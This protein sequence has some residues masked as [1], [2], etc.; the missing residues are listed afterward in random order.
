MPLAVVTRSG[1]TCSWS[2]ANQSPV[3]QKP[4]WISSAMKT[5]PLARQYAA[6]A[7]QE[8]VRRHDEA[9]LALHRLDHHGGDVLLADLRVDQA[10]HDVEGFLGALGRAA[11]PAERIGHRHPV[12]LAGE[13]PEALLVG[14]VLGGHG[15]RQVGP[16][17]VGVVEDHDRVPAGGVPGDLDGV[18]DRLGTGVEQRGPLLVCAR[19][20]PV[21]LLA[22]LDVALVRRHHEAGVGEL[23]DL[24]DHPADDLVGA[25]A[26]RGDGDAGAEVDE[27]VAVD[28]DDDAA[29]RRGH[30]DRQD[31]AQAAGNA[32]LTALEQLTGHRAGDLGDEI[33]V[34][35]QGRAAVRDRLRAHTSDN[36]APAGSSAWWYLDESAR[37]AAC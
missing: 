33:A 20:Q 19:R 4:D 8:A 1:T 21:E 32:P 13:R 34:L 22:H 28:V 37:R 11:G 5:M 29:A 10:G 14:H 3:R 24:L 26:D 6:S 17:V 16:A 7:R 35:G 12:D 31:V 18:L 9:A 27:R 36:N 2:Q 23:G 15:H 25:V 30:E